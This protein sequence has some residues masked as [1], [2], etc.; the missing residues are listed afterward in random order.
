MKNLTRRNFLKNSALVAGATFA[1][2]L[3]SSGLPK[4][5]DD[6]KALV[7]VLLEGG[8]DSFSMLVP[9][10]SPKAYDSYRAVRGDLALDKSGL[11]DLR[12][13]HYALHPNMKKMQRLYNS[14][15]MAIVANVGVLNSP[16][17]SEQIKLLK[18]GRG[19]A[20]LPES[21]F[22]HV[23]QQ[24]AWMGFDKDI[25]WGAKFADMQN[26]PLTNISLGGQNSLQSGGQFEPLIAYDESFGILNDP[27]NI[28]EK[29]STKYISNYFDDNGVEMPLAKQLEMVAKFIAMRGELGAPKRQVF[30]VKDSGWDSHDHTQEEGFSIAQK[31]AKLDS[32]LG[33]FS[34]VLKN[35]GVSD[36]VTTF[37]FSEFGRTL[38][39][40]TK[41]GS[42]HGWGGVAFAFGGAV[43]G[44]LYGNMPTF[45]TNAHETLANSVVVP[46]T[47]AKS[48]MATMFEWLSDG[49]LRRDN[50]LSIFS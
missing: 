2:P 21:L 8:A 25:G 14:Q 6:Y 16:I 15:D 32:A 40:Y 10:H 38:K 29:V 12:D 13:T 39:S 47:S 20:K 48:Y 43:K 41:K 36:N 35:V 11:L 30:F 5:N 27:T 33:E 22:C 31:V 28:T 3:I 42:D 17:T 4:A 18:S 34:R 24:D 45:S 19:E 1:S 46:T 49:D 37:T 7:C 26:H 9:K 44:G 50:T 23:T